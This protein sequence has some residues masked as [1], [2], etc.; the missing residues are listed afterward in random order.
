M[1]SF[2]ARAMIHTISP[3]PL[4]FVI[5][6]NDILVSTSSQ[7]DAFNKT[8]EPKQLHYLEGCGHSDI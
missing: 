5:P 6:G 3:T 8:R 4:L 1:L 2:E 7:M